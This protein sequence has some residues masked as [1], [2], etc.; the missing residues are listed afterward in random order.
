[1]VRGERAKKKKEYLPVRTDVEEK[2]NE[3]ERKGGSHSF[4]DKKNTCCRCC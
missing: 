4:F 1:M 3:R 2:I